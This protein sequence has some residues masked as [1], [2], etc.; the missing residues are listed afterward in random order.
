METKFSGYVMTEIAQC[1]LLPIIGRVLKLLMDNR[2]V[3]HIC[4]TE[5]THPKYLAING[6]GR[7]F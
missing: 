3:S 2:I 7:A 1:T 4:W 5:Q 6:N